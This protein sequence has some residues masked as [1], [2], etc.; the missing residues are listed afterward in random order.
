MRELRNTLE[1]S[2]IRATSSVI[3]LRDIEIAPATSP[4]AG[5]AMPAPTSAVPPGESLLDHLA[6]R[7]A[8]IVRAMLEAVGWNQSEAARRLGVSESKIRKCVK[9]YGLARPSDPAP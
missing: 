8:H 9:E 7:E 4:S 2:A 3:G 1:R 6:H 5:E